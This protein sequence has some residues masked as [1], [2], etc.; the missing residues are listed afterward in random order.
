MSGPATP[1]A[2]GQV[3]PVSPRGIHGHCES[4][5][6]TPQPNHL[7]IPVILV[8]NQKIAVNPDQSRKVLFSSL[9]TPPSIRNR[10]PYALPSSLLP[11]RQM[12]SL[13]FIPGNNETLLR[14]KG[15]IGEA[16]SERGSFFSRSG[17]G[18]RYRSLIEFPAH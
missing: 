3:H 13:T 4:I 14:R 1:R 6:S 2:T 10:F 15:R 16:A 18:A 11:H 12:P 17:G 5:I 9:L 8:N 7:Q